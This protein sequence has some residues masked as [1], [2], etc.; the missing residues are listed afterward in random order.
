VYG[1]D[2]IVL[3][4]E[5]LE[6]G[7][8]QLE[9]LTGVE[10]AK[11]G[12][13]DKGG[14]HNALAS[15]GEGLYLE[16]VAPV[17]GGESSSWVEGLRGQS[18]P[19]PFAFAVRSNSLGALRDRAV[20]AGLAPHGPFADGRVTPAGHRLDW[21]LLDFFNERFGLFFPFFIDWGASRHPSLDAPRGL[22]L[23]AFRFEHPAAAE[24]SR[25]F[26]LLGVSVPVEPGDRAR[27][28]TV[29]ETPKGQVGLS[30]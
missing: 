17:P 3:G 18:V 4:S 7:I 1:I 5:V 9:R 10:A 26:W 6:D 19:T 24:L 20:A 23:I 14:T 13:H 29:F 15:L 2:H 11:G 22:S 28:E 21:H 30:S 8:S 16:I 27:F 12:A 25:L